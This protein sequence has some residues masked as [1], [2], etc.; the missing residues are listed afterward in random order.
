M[1][2]D[3]TLDRIVALWDAAKKNDADA[4]LLETEA[5]NLRMRGDDKRHEADGLWEPLLEAHPEW[6]DA[7]HEEL[8]PRVMP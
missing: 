5:N 6:V 3:E 7:F 1:T 4:D 2:T 8:D